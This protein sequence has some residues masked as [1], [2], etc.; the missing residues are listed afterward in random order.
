VFTVKIFTSVA[1][2]PPKEVFPSSSGD[3]KPSFN[4]SR[5]IL[6]V[7]GLPK[8][9]GSSIAKNHSPFPFLSVASSV[10]LEIDLFS[11]AI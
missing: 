11:L 5:L 4:T 1:L 2:N 8:S 7:V 9:F 10:Y 6:Y 3:K